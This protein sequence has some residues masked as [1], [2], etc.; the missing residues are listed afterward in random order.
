ML[1]SDEQVLHPPFRTFCLATGEDEASM[2]GDAEESD[3]ECR[4]EDGP[5]VLWE[6]CIQ[7]SIFVDLSEDESLHLSDLENSLAFRVSPTESA[8][9]EPSIHLSGKSQSQ[10]PVELAC[11][12]CPV[13]FIKL[14]KSFV[15]LQEQLEFKNK[16]Q[17]FSENQN[18]SWFQSWV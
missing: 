2:E 3:E 13:L 15:M 1:L 6:K 12:V 5:T 7:Q 10:R 11:L 18:T 9:S 14:S 8:A 4:V 17:S 16:T